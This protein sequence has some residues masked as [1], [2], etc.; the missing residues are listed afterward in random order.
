MNEE[1]SAAY[2]TEIKERANE[3]LIRSRVIKG[4]PVICSELIKELGKEVAIEVLPF[5]WIE[6]Q[7]LA[8][9]YTF[10]F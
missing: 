8:R 2:K 9:P 6:K 4:F 7:T 1:F 10:L 5:S 3:I